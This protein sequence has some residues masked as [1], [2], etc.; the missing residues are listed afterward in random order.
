MGGDCTDQFTIGTVT[1]DNLPVICGQNTGQHMYVDMGTGCGNVVALNF[2]FNGA[3]NER[4]WEIKAT[5][6]PCG[7]DYTPPDGCLQY[8]TELDGRFTTFNFLP[9]ND[10]HLA[11]QQ[12]SICIRQ[13]EGFCCIQYMVCNDV[14]ETGMTLNTKAMEIPMMGFTDT[15]CSMDYVGIAGSGGVCNTAPGGALVSRYCGT[16]LNFVDM[17]KE[18]APICG[19]VSL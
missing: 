3:S 19:K 10:N 18:H 16:K 5:Q 11:Q 9:T 7:S 17:S 14:A 6:I 2:A 15:Y 4:L 12:Y 8:H 13:E 1:N